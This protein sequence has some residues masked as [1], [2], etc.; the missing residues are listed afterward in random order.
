VRAAR[1]SPVAP[2]QQSADR[3]D[4]EGDERNQV[5]KPELT[6]AAEMLRQREA[7]AQV[8]QPRG[9][10]EQQAEEQRCDAGVL[11]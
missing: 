4:D 2:G 6:A 1:V 8:R 9:R 3:R 7:R 11:A 10:R 5:Q